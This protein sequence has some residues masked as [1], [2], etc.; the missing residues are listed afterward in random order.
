MLMKVEGHI[1]DGGFDGD[2]MFMVLAGRRGF[3]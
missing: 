1:G 2:A 3:A